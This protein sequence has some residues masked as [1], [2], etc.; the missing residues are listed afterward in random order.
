MLSFFETI[1]IEESV[2]Y[3][4]VYNSKIKISNHLRK[5]L[6]TDNDVLF[7]AKFRDHL[8][9][10]VE[11]SSN[12]EFLSLLQNEVSQK[13][14]VDPIRVIRILEQDWFFE[15][16]TFFSGVGGLAAIL[17]LIY[18]ILKE[19][20]LQEKSVKPVV[21]I[22]S[23]NG[24]KC[25]QKSY[26]NEVVVKKQIGGEDTNT[27]SLEK[28]KEYYCEH[29]DSFEVYRKDGTVIRISNQQIKT[30]IDTDA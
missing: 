19:G 7:V 22:T 23:A 20:K 11:V 30:I 4:L 25:K 18:Q 21:T 16:C 1:E 29:L 3:K 2:L 12:L 26:Q 17:Q 27:Y 15:V 9:D 6:K 5:Y 14:E 28:V 10:L 8:P 24:K 13:Q